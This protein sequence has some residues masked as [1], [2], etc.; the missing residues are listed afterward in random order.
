[1]LQLLPLAGNLN[2]KFFKSQERCASIRKDGTV[3]MSPSKRR[4]E[5]RVLLLTLYLLTWNIG[6]AP[7]NAGKWQ[8]GFN[9]TFKGL[10]EILTEIFARRG[11][12]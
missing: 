3:P 7:N 6:R 4:P 10:I 5:E 2:F 8:M 1:V 12:D 11:V 9:L